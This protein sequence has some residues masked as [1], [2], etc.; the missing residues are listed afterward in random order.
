MDMRSTVFESPEKIVEDINNYWEY[1]PA[2]PTKHCAL[3][4]DAGS[5]VHIHLQVSDRTVYHENGRTVVT[6]L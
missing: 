1:D 2:R 6:E 3:L 4:H 5:G